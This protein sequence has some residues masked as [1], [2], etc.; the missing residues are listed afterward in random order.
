[1]RAGPRRVVRVADLVVPTGVALIPLLHGLDVL[2]F[3]LLLVLL[4]FIGAADGPSNSAKG[5]FMPEV[6]ANSRV[7][8]ERVTGLVGTVERTATVLGPAIAGVVVAAWG[9]AT[10]LWIT[11]GLELLGGLLVAVFLPRKERRRAEKGSYRRELREGAAFLKRDRLLMSMYGMITVTNLIDTAMF[12]VLIPVW[13]QETG[14]GPTAIGLLARSLSGAAIVSSLLASA[15]GDR[16]PRRPAYRLR[17]GLGGVPRCINLATAV[18]PRWL[19]A[20]HPFPGFAI[21]FLSPIIAAILFERV[22]EHLPGRVRTLG[23]SL[24]WAGI[25]FGGVIAG[26]AITAI[27]LSPAF[28]VFGLVHL[29]AVLVPSFR[30]EWSEMDRRAAAVDDA[31]CRN[32][33]LPAD[34]L[35]A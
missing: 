7:P 12:S 14:H 18:P 11:A 1:D 31:A 13:A 25:P 27:G 32:L 28:L 6:A 2:T 22:P 10:S 9:A 24:A 17:F 20:P 23:G 30:P 8:L 4:A 19:V 21:G 16:I 26:A 34:T 29:L 35:V 33:S 5:I 15:Y 3:P